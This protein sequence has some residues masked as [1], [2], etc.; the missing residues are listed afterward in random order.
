MTVMIYMAVN[1]K[2][3]VQTRIASII[4]L[5]I[6][7]LTVIVCLI[8]VFTDTS[9]P[10]DPSRLIVGEPPPVQEKSGNSF[11]LILLI[12]FLVAMLVM[13]AVYARREAKKYVQ[14]DFSNIKSISKW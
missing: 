4:A 13:V 7:V 14:D 5:T 8:V 10:I 9:V 11:V 1:K 3:N 6:M 2:S 12:L